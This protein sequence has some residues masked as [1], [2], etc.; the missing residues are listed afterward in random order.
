M[1]QQEL[2]KLGL[3]EKEVKI[4][5]ALLELGEGNIQQISKKSKVKRTTVYDI[6]ESLKEK[7]LLGQTTR[8]K[9]IYYLAEDPRKLEDN[10]EDKKN[11]FRK[12]L[13]EL[14]SITNILDK[15]P[16]I[17]YYEGGEGIKEVYRDTLKYPNQEL[18][19]WV[20]AE[21]V[22]SFDPEFLNEYY[23][24]RRLKNKIWVR[25]I[26]PNKPYMQKYKLLDEKSL[27][28]T[29]LISIENIP[30]EVEI[31]LYGNNKIA[32]MSFEEKLSLIIESKKIFNTL[33][34]IFEMN[35]KLLV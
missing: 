23:L 17:K 18:L 6:I 2:I 11:I 1:L 34:S 14:L 32:I 16:K 21:A 5:L 24:P 13:P 20:S 30:L 22:S 35:W 12:V 25:A 4:Y 8:K 3:N 10:L 31:N 33:K 27:R 9:R 29:K 7:G 26:A 28:R 19:A 15:K